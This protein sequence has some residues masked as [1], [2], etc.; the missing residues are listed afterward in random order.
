MK[1]ASDEPP[2]LKVGITGSAA[3]G[4]DMLDSAAEKAFRNTELTTVVLVVV[5]LLVVYRAPLL[6]LIPLITIGVA[7]SSSPATPWRCWRMRAIARA[8]EWWHFKIFTTTK[9]LSWS[10][11]CS[12]PAPIFVCF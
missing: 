12:A 1:R 6:V 2:G 3:I 4:G 7:R 10:S 11:C 5:I 8:F 9:I